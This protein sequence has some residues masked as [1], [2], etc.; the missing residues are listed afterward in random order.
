MKEEG[1]TSHKI[2]LNA[3]GNRFRVALG[4]RIA[5]WEDDEEVNLG[6]V[7]LLVIH[8]IFE[9]CR[10]LFQNCLAIHL[11]SDEEKFYCLALMAHKLV[12]L[13][14]NEVNAESLDN[15]QFQVIFTYKIGFCLYFG[16]IFSF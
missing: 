4:D 16:M 11:D 1:I 13:V 7:F 9:A 10:L 3:L 12:G 8:F 14:K 5:P 6:N 2:A 15:P